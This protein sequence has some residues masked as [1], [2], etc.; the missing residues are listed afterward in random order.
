MQLRQYTTMGKLV[1]SAQ[2]GLKGL[3]LLGIRLAHFPKKSAI[4]KQIL[5][6]K[7]RLGQR[8]ISDIIDLPELTDNNQKIAEQ[9]IMEMRIPAYLTG[10]TNLFALLVL[11]AVALSLKHG[12]THNSALAYASYGLLLCSAFN[13]PKDGNAMG[14]LAFSLNER[15]PNIELTPRILFLYSVFIHP[16][17]SHWRL[18][19]QWLNKAIEAGYQ[20]GDVLFLATSA[21]HCVIWDP[22]LDLKTSCEEQQ[23][24]M[25]IIHKYRY[26]NAADSAQLFLH[27]CLNFQGLTPEDDSMNTDEFDELGC[28]QRMEE[29]N[30]ISGVTVYYLL[31]AEISFFYDRYS[32]A[33]EYILQ[34]DKTRQ[35]IMGTPFSARFCFMAFL[36]F[37]HVNPSSK[38]QQKYRDQRLQQEHKQMKLWADHCPVNFKHLQC[39]MQAEMARLSDKCQQASQYY[40]QAIRF[41]HNNGWRRDEA[42]ANE[43]AAKFHLY[44]QQEKPASGYMQEARYLYY[45]WGAYRKV[46]H[47]E[48]NFPQLLV[49]STKQSSLETPSTHSETTTIYQDPRLIKALDFSSV[50]KIS[51][52]ISGE[53]VLSTLLKKMMTV[54]IENAGAEKGFLLLEEQNEW[55]IQARGSVNQQTHQVLEAISIDDGLLSTAVIHYVSKVKQ[56]LVLDDATKDERFSQD[57]YVI[58]EQPKSLLC[59]PILHQNNLTAILY[60]ENNLTTGVFTAERLEILTILSSQTAISLQNAHLYAH[61]EDKVEQRTQVLNETLQEVEAKN[62]LISESIEYASNIQNSLLPATEL[63]ADLFSDFFI[64][65]QPRDVVGGD[66]YLVEKVD[67]GFLLMVFDCT[68]HGVPG[69]LMT[70]MASSGIR[71]IIDKGITDDPAKILTELNN[72]IKKSLKQDLS[73]KDIRSDDGLDGSICFIDKNK[74]QMTFAGAKS[75]LIHITN[76]ELKVIKGDR[77]SVGYKKSTFDYGYTNHTLAINPDDFFTLCS[78]GYVDQVGGHKPMPFGNKRFQKLILDNMDR[79]FLEQKQIIMETLKNHQGEQQRRDDIVVFCFRF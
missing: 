21:Q 9:L 34:S 78:D 74:Q 39:I 2:V 26:Q 41:A 71:H 47:V 66:I 6:I 36:S 20:S 52:A 70:M 11:K 65:W 5:L 54:L 45:R 55:K 79:P 42:L 10:N 16:W 19:T 4:I 43:L 75:A 8:N 61:L 35:S 68:G 63:L 29:Q 49:H 46:T 58:K 18:M 38:K 76:K 3:A 22:T 51:Q 14:K 12:H 77:K 33:L 56:S 1:E 69:A 64:W 23:T 13:N 24:Y 30:F 73:I 27:M 25:K 67:T 59:I 44:R 60:L 17:N 28:L 53:I 48:K 31:K 50:T 72:F 62:A 32:D 15:Y 37:S 7:W 57:A 40:D